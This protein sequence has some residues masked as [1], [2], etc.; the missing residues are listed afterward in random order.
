MV[1]RP[2][3]VLEL[4]AAADPLTRRGEPP[5]PAEYRLRLLV[6]EITRALGFRVAAVRP[7]EGTMTEDDGMGNTAPSKKTKATTAPTDDAVAL[8][9][10]ALSAPFDA[11]EVK[12]KPQSVRSN[13]A[14]ASM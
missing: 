2:R 10:A 14:L 4:E 5:R 3:Y 11:G 6:K 1:D 12:F 7:D 13:R 8:L 9:T